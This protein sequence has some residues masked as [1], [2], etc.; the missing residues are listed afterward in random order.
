MSNGIYLS[1][2]FRQGPPTSTVF[3]DFSLCSNMSLSAV[4]QPQCTIHVEEDPRCKNRSARSE[5]FGGNCA[6][7]PAQSVEA[8]STNWS[9]E[10]MCP[11]NPA[12]CS[13][14]AYSAN[15]LVDLMK[16]LDEFFGCKEILTQPSHG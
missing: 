14:A 10:A 2:S 11:P 1:P 16:I 8:T 6:A 3:S 5:Q 13:L 12:P 15:V 9:F 4:P 7:R